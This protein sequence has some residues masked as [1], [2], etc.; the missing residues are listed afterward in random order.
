MICRSK[1]PTLV[2]FA[3]PEPTFPLDRF[4]D[5]IFEL[6]SHE[7]R[8]RRRREHLDTCRMDLSGVRTIPPVA[9][10]VREQRVSWW[11][12]AVVVCVCVTALMGICR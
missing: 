8:R 1:N 11:P 12:M 10:P 3:L 2:G 7:E 5:P 9:A 4:G 6:I